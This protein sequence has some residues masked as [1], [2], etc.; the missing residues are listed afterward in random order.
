V[1]TGQWE[2]LEVALTTDGASGWILPPFLVQRHEG[3]AVATDAKS[4]CNQG[5][6]IS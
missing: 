2:E 6:R 1:R 3:G 5:D 4:L